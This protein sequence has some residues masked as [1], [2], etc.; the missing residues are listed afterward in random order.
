MDRRYPHGGRKKAEPL[1]RSAFTLG[2]IVRVARAM[3]MATLHP[4]V[5]APIDKAEC[6]AAE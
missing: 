5:D 3:L 4:P 6:Q 1:A 2:S